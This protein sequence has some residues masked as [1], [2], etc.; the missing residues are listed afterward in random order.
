M[1]ISTYHLLIAA[2]LAA[3]PAAAQQTIE[4][5]REQIEALPDLTV[6]EFEIDLSSPEGLIRSM[7]EISR[8]DWTG[9]LPEAIT[10][11]ILGAAP[12]VAHASVVWEMQV[13]GSWNETVAGTG[14]LNVLDQTA[15]GVA[16]GRQ[17]H[18]VLDTDARDWPFHLFSFVPDTAPA[19]AWTHFSGP[20]DGH[21]G[22]GTGF[23]QIA[24]HMFQFDRLLGYATPQGM[25]ATGFAGTTD[26]DFTG[27]YLYTEVQG[28]RIRV[29]SSG[30]AYRMSFSA[31]VLEFHSEDRSP[32]GRSASLRMYQ[33]NHCSP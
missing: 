9:T 8:T 13:S 26:A 22:G 32:T 12:F 30:N 11:M 25:E 3:G 27:D 17:F 2:A 24:N 29:D 31:T 28:G 14:A 10:E 1:K 18:A 7:E 15:L 6:P 20:S 23:S 19:I 5:P 16:P 21:A 4:I 33:G